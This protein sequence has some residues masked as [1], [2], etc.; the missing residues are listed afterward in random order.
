MSKLESYWV[1]DLHHTLPSQQRVYQASEA[2]AKI[3]ELESMLE[4]RTKEV[5]S[6]IE[7]YDKNITKQRGIIQEQRG[8]LDRLPLDVQEK[9][10]RLAR[11]GE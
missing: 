8:Q 7:R 3:K 1:H 9:L 11:R 5:D 2:D 6:W 10:A 4:S